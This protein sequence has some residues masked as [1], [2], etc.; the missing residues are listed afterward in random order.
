MPF[1]TNAVPC[2]FLRF[3]SDTK[4]VGVILRLNTTI[5]EFFCSILFVMINYRKV[6]PYILSEEDLLANQNRVPM[7]PKG[8]FFWSPL[9]TGAGAGAVPLKSECTCTRLRALRRWALGTS[10]QAP[11]SGHLGAGHLGAGYLGAGHGRWSRLSL[12]HAS[13]ILDQWAC[14][15]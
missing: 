15:I 13:P 1:G 12:F 14:S 10:N 3:S 2:G 8:G 7:C 5:F 4:V 6:R 11:G 9:G